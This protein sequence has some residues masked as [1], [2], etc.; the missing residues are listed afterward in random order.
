MPTLPATS[1]HS[2]RL[3]FRIITP[4]HLTHQNPLSLV[5]ERT[6]QPG[7]VVSLCLLW[8]WHV[9]IYF[10]QI[11][12]NDYFD[13]IFNIEH[14]AFT[15]CIY[16]PQHTYSNMLHSCLHSHSSLE[17]EVDCLLLWPLLSFSD[18]VTTGVFM[19]SF[20]RPAEQMLLETS[21]VWWVFDSVSFLWEVP[22]QPPPPPPSLLSQHVSVCFYLRDQSPN[23][24]VCR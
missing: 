1:Y 24:L 6:T 14:P 11:G 7:K 13:H 4:E 15:L 17:F 21:V 8:L 3:S 5:I 9:N 22:P 23:F 19:T 18:S 10:Q 20:L 2:F 16:W 12:H